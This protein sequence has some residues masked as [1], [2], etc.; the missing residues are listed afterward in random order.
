MACCL[1]KIRATIQYVGL[2]R[3][4]RDH[5]EFHKAIREMHNNFPRWLRQRVDS[6]VFA[7]MFVL[8]A[9]ASNRKS[10]TMSSA[11]DLDS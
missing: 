9:P 7:V 2:F 4:L 11:F 1:M 5:A 6:R 10:G 8:E 3:G